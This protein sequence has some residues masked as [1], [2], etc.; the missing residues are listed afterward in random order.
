MKIKIF[1][2]LLLLGCL[3]SMLNATVIS[4]NGIAKDSV[5]GLM[6]QDDYDAKTIEKDWDGAKAYCLDLRLGGYKDWRLPNI[7]ELNTLLDNT[8]S[9]EPFVIDGIENID[10]NYYWSS[11]AYASDSS[12]S[13]VVNFYGGWDGHPPKTDSFYVRCVRAGQLDFDS[14]TLLQKKGKL[15]IAQKEIDSIK[16]KS[17]QQLYLEAGKLER[18]G[19]S[20]KSKMIYNYIVDNYPD[21]DFAVKA[22]DKLTS[23]SRAENEASN[24]RSQSSQECENTKNACLAGCGTYI[25]GADA[26][27][28]SVWSCNDRCKKINCY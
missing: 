25:S 5:T 14:L 8:K 16:P 22:S 20:Y 2:K 13:W 26:H 4:K 28:N 10:S 7:Y 21:S 3:G 24:R 19:D 27:N 17:P 12:R 6:W 1:A 23:A 9:S 18:N 11:T 15:K